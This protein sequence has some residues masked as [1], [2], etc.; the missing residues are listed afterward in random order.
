MFASLSG[1]IKRTQCVSVLAVS[2]VKTLIH[3]L[4]ILGVWPQVLI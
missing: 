3:Q 1:S 4:I 2:E